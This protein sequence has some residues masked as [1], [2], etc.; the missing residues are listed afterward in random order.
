[1]E[2]MEEKKGNKP[3]KQF[4]AGAIRASVWSNPGKEEFGKEQTTYN[5]VS[6]ERSYKDKA[7]NWQSTTSMRTNDLPRV[8]LVIQQA[9]Q[10]LVMNKDDAEEV[11][12]A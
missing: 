2:P 4:R 12:V 1:M 3:V 7:G 10:F 11:E 6:L 8:T 9:Y 5:T